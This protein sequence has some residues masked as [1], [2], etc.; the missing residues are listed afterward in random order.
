MPEGKNRNMTRKLYQDNA[1]LFDFTAVVQKTEPTDEGVEVVLDAT[2]FY[3][4]SGGQL[5][6]LGNLD[7]HPVLNV[8]E[9]DR[10]EILHLVKDGTFTTGQTVTG[11]IDR[12]RRLDNMRKHTGQHILSQAFLREV[13]AK[14]I[15][16]HLSEVAC[17]IELARDNF[18]SD[19]SDRVENAANDIVMKNLPVT[20]GWYDR[21]QLQSMN[22]RKIPKR[23][24][25]LRIINIGEYDHTACGGTHCNSTG[26]VGLIKIVASEK[27][28]GH[29]RV[30]FLVGLHALEDYR[31]KHRVTSEL[32]ARLTC[33]HTDL[34]DVVRRQGEQVIAL[35]RENA[36]Y[37]NKLFELE[38]PAIIESAEKYGDIH[39]VVR[40][41]DGTDV[42][43]LKD[44][45]LKIT[46]DFAA[47]ALMYADDKLLLAA[48]KDSGLSAGNIIKQLADKYSLRGGGNPVLAQSG[49]IEPARMN[50]IIDTALNLI[51]ENLAK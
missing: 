48:S 25:R 46:N 39:L 30:T 27:I 2:A 19:D 33:H 32:S 9:N 43:I 13:D 6:D 12:I 37:R 42:K 38:L 21:E 17:T 26:E 50:E 45:A 49:G 47:V 29:I 34:A 7:R 8:Y 18:T 22:I 14:T 44:Q 20:M 16:A 35:H 23:D 28:R 3:P 15:S 10:E 5:Y 31:Q 4:E 11:Q 40:Q 1:Y 36:Q 41:A 24:G 51:R